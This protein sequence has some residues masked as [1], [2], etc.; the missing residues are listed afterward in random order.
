MSTSTIAAPSNT[1][2]PGRIILRVILVL[3][4]L[5]V[6]LI[7]GGSIW[8][9]RA[10]H[11]SLPQVDGTIAIPGL[12]APV[13]IVRDAHG[14][15]HISAA[16]LEDLFFAQGYTVAQDRLWQIDMARGYV[17]GETPEIL[18]ASPGPWLK[19]DRQQRI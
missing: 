17:D 6:L 12:K 8:F 9:Y 19:H 16:N 3:I 10:A 14:V 15:P 4:L 18:P 2:R 5:V 7:A 11:A 1:R 13:E